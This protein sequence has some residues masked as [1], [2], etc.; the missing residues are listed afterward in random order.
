[1]S[2]FA[3]F[4]DVS[5]HYE[6]SGNGP[7]SLILIHE[8]SG[9]LDSWD[10]L[11]PELEAD[12]KI[13]RTDQRGAGLSEKVRTQFSAEDLVVDTERLIAITGLLPPFYVAGIASG[14][15]IAVAFAARP[16]QDD[17]AFAHCKCRL[18]N[19]C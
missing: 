15:A 7:R 11:M 2:Q 5:L 4:P 8:L 18:S 14:A 1:M 12:F 19:T 16:P 6:V 10:L 17:A 3:D 13:L 9:T